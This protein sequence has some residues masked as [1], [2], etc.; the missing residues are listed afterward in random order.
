MDFVTL[1]LEQ[2]E[3]ELLA[4]GLQLKLMLIDVILGL[5]DEY[6]TTAQQIQ[7]V[8]QD[9]PSPE[10]TV[11]MYKVFRHVTQVYGQLIGELMQRL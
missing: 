10:M 1:Q 2:M 11:A 9:D 8:L 5:M 4:F 3:L 7:Q 6:M